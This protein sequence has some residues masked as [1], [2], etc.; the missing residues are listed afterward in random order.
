MITNRRLFITF[1]LAANF[2]TPVAARQTPADKTF[3]VR[4]A[5]GAS[6]AT[7]RGTVK[8]YQT[9]DY[10][11]SAR[12]GQKMTVRVENVKGKGSPYFVVMRKGAADNVTPVPQQ[13]WSGAL[14]ATGEYTVRV[15]LYRNEA[16]RGE[17]S[18]YRLTV[19]VK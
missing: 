6:S 2:V 3:P 17:S 11:L 7:L 10:K 8:G 18:A 4:F 9:H 15:L 14:P 13:E 5:R 1:L 16:R 12:A 19:S